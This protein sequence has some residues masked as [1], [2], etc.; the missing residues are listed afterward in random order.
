MTKRKLLL[1]SAVLLALAVLPASAIVIVDV[2]DIEVSPLEYNFGDVVLGSSATT[3]VTISNA[4]QGALVVSGIGLELGGSADFSIVSVPALPVELAY[5]DSVTV[6]IGYTAS[7]VGPPSAVLG[8]ASKDPNESLVEV[9]LSGTGV[10]PAP[11]PPPLPPTIDEVISFLDEAVEAGTLEGTGRWPRVARAR[12]RA[13]RSMLE[14]AKV[15]IERNRTNAAWF[16]LRNAYRLADGS[17]RPP[18]F[19]A[20]EACP[21]LA[22]MILE[23]METLRE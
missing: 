4:G 2:P 14:I 19:V 12:L 16:I 8:I 1:A 11:P 18:D 10:E 15:L 21:E 17:P 23:V 9:A 13:F 6:E 5:L 7:A 20:G 3:T 22:S